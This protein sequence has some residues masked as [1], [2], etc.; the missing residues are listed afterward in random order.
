MEKLYKEMGKKRE[1]LDGAIKLI[2]KILKN[3]IEN[4]DDEKFRSIKR[5]NPTIKD[6]LTGFKSGIEIIKLLGF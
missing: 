5:D 1:R 4:P 3:I 6:K 2:S